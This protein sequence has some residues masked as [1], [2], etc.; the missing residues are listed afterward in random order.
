M[1]GNGNSNKQEVDKGKLGMLSVS[2]KLKSGLIVEIYG[3]FADQKGHTDSYILQ[4]F[5]GY[6][7]DKIDAGV[8]YS[9]EWIQQENLDNKQ[10]GVLSGFVTGD[11][12]ECISLLLRGD[13]VFDPVPKAD[14]ID[15]LPLNP[16]SKFTLIIFGIDFHPI[17]NVK[18]I[19]N[20]E[21]VS[22][23]GNESGI[24]SDN[25]LFGRLTFLWS[26]N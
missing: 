16:D 15:Y 10:L 13:R 3:D 20:L 21:F 12:S 2:A 8:Q 18:F 11:V 25:D 23:D 22:Y 5:L 4:G 9:N 26:F 14:G 1:Y 7:S 24:A 17:K 19:P 6:Q